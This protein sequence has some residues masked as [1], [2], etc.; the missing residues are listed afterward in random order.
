MD[1]SVDRAPRQSVQ[2]V[3]Q[4][5]SRNLGKV[6]VAGSNPVVRSRDVFTFD[7]G[8]TSRFEPTSLPGFR[9]TYLRSAG[10]V[11]PSA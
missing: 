7:M 3:Y 6:R 4:D 2:A 5:V 10:R 11:T 8:T 1:D 9:S